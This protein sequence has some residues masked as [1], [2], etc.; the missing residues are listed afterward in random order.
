[1]LGLWSGLVLELLLG[2]SKSE[3]EDK[4]LGLVGRVRVRIIFREKYRLQIMVE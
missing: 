1:M 2:A 4:S 3:G